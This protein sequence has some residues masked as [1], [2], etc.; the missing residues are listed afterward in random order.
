M[1]YLFHEA[2]EAEYMDAVDFYENRQLGLG[3]RLFNE[4]QAIL[5]Q[6]CETPE[7]W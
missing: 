4:I 7:V 6:I 3:R 5:Q 1:R 2:A